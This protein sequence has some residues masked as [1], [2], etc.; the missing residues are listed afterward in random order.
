MEEVKA[1]FK[2][3]FEVDYIN[4]PINCNEIDS[5]EHML[6]NMYKIKQSNVGR[7]C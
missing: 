4:L 6:K 7:Y 5:Q 1:N 3:A 2:R